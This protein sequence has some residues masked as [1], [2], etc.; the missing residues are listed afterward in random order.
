[1]VVPITTKAVEGVVVAIPTPV[2]LIVNFVV[3]DWELV[4][5]DP[6]TGTLKKKLLLV[7]FPVPNPP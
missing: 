6:I 5:L 7:A 4:P 1:V 2:E 3:V